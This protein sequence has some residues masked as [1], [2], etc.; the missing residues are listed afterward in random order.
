MNF[1]PLEQLSNLV[2]GYQ[3]AFKVGR[4]NILLCQ[5]EGEVFA[6]EN[7]CPHMDV[8]LDRATQLPGK[9]IR[10]NAHGIEFELESGSAR[11][12]LAGMCGLKKY[13]LI[14]EGTQV[15]IELD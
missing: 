5:L 9:M 11:G 4:E 3:R 12:P 2:D 13:D 7:R 10:C 14:Y 6:I 1:Y 8:P 15:G